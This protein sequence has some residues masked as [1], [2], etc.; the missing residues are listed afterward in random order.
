MVISTVKIVSRMGAEVSIRL[1]AKGR[2][3]HGES[4]AS[5][6]VE[7]KMQKKMKRFTNVYVKNFGENLPAEKLK[8]VFSKFGK[9]TSY[10][11]KEGAAAG[12][13]GTGE[14]E[15]RKKKKGF[16]TN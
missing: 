11:V 5:R 13:E 8:E 6:K 12:E 2:S 3:C 15:N 9:I 7:Y 14:D 16:V 10:Y 1:L 4:S